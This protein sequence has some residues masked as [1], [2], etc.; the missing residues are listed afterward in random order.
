MPLQNFM[1][2]VENN[3]NNYCYLSRDAVCS[4][5]AKAV[6]VQKDKYIYILSF[7]VNTT[8]LSTDSEV[9]NI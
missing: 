8:M 1:F 9:L 6:T 2:A 5:E 7:T 4:E 3:M